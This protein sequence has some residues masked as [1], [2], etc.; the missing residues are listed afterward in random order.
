MIRGS[1]PGRETP[2]HYFLC[3]SGPGADTI[4]TRQ[5]ILHETCV[6]ASDAICGSH[7][8]FRSVQ[9]TKHRHTIFY[10]VVGQSA[11]PKNLCDMTHY[12]ELVFLV[13]STVT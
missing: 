4:K 9:S 13:R 1:H 8:V 2:T 12:V 6:F 10:S 7:S 3:S 11:D 5:D